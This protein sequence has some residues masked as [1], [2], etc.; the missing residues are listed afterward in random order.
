MQN[1][2]FIL[3]IPD[4]SGEF[5]KKYN[6]KRFSHLPDESNSWTKPYWYRTTFYVPSADQ[7]S[8]FQLIFKGINNRATVWPNGHG[9]PDQ[10]RY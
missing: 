6:L 8:H 5:N 10:L 7:G 1:Y 2:L 3:L 9:N 4:A